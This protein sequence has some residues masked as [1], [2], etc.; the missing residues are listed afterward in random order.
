MDSIRPGMGYRTIHEIPVPENVEAFLTREGVPLNTRLFPGDRGSGPIR[1]QEYSFGGISLNNYFTNAQREQFLKKERLKYL[2]RMLKWWGYFD[3]PVAERKPISELLGT[4]PYREFTWD[5]YM[6]PKYQ[7][8]IP[9]PVYLPVEYAGGPLYMNKGSLTVDP[10][11]QEEFTEGEKVNVLYTK[12]Q[13]AR[14][15]K[16]KKVNV[17]PS[18]IFRPTSVNSMLERGSLINPMTREKVELRQRRTLKFK[19]NATTNQNASNSNSNNNSVGGKRK[20]KKTRK[21]TRRH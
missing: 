17:K 8:P 6:S 11:N 15:N 19:N 2:Y 4:N 9:K 16:G 7:H 20:M 5:Q 12:N 13:L 3:T 18:M 10:I 21:S 14:L 1:G